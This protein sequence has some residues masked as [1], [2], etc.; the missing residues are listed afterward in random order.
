[1]YLLNFYFWNKKLQ[2]YLLEF[3]N[4]VFSITK[5][6]SC[7]VSIKVGIIKS[8][9][10]IIEILFGFLYLKLN[11]LETRTVEKRERSEH[12]IWVR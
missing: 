11:D 9:K 5:V 7:K 8:V 1:M 4:I 12:L 3:R 6:V 10:N 2:S